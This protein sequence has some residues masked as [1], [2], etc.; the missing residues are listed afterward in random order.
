M[1]TIRR[2]TRSEINHLEPEQKL[3]AIRDL[4]S[5]IEISVHA[6]TGGV[7]IYSGGKINH[8]TSSSPRDAGLV[9]STEAAA[10]LAEARRLVGFPDEQDQDEGLAALRGAGPATV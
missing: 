9:A 10:H 4:L 7:F 3:A 2:R 8:L 6:P 5:G 1:S